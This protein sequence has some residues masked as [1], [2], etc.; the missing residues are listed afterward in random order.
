MYL[1][2]SRFINIYKKTDEYSVYH[3][4]IGFSLKDN[5]NRDKMTPSVNIENN[6]CVYKILSIYL[7][8]VVAFNL[9]I[10]FNEIIYLYTVYYER[11][12]VYL[13]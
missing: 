8:K 9:K 2:Y 10:V 3:N 12:D 11:G 1:F 6:N 5:V 7:D 4:N 13:C